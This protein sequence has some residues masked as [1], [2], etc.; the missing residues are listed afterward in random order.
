M[1]L[2]A[3]YQP[4]SV[5]DYIERAMALIA[6]PDRWCQS[7]LV[8]NSGR[9][10]AIGALTAVVFGDG[11]YGHLAM[12][13]AMSFDTERGTAVSVPW[14]LMPLID[15][16]NEAI[17]YLDRA[18]HRRGYDD[19]MRL[20]DH[21]RVFRKWHHRRVLQTMSEAAKRAR[22]EGINNLLTTLPA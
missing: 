2:D 16:F 19:I 1:P 22:A 12:N 18:A 20:N 8:D 21:P 11:D 6:T 5:A 13:M 9:H 7:K 4:E 15:S 3:G 14:R 17:G 10:C